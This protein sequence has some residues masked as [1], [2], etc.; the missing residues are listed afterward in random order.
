MITC[1][2]LAAGCDSIV[3][4][5]LATLSSATDMH[6]IFVLG[7]KR[8]NRHDSLAL[9]NSRHQNVHQALASTCAKQSTHAADSLF[10]AWGA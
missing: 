3:S 5:D 9:Q 8:D 6:Q 10:H 2:A 1:N 4:V 7:N